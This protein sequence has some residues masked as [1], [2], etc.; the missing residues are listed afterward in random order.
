MFCATVL[1]PRKLNHALN[2][3]VGIC[4]D[5]GLLEA[6]EMSKDH[7]ATTDSERLRVRQ[8]HAADPTVIKEQ[9]DE[10]VE[11]YAWFLKNRARSGQNYSKYLEDLL[12]LVI[13][14]LTPL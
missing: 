5:S 3:P 10:I 12:V 4:S 1:L 11:E 7:S 14:V 2:W 6:V 8:E 13:M 9:W